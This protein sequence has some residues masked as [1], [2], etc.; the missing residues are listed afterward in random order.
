[1]VDE[2]VYGEARLEEVLNSQTVWLHCQV[3]DQHAN[4]MLA[5]PRLA[6]AERLVKLAKSRTVWINGIG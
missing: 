1:M 2:S 6:S 5:R 4:P 3:G